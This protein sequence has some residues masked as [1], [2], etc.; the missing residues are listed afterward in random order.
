M[1]NIYTGNQMPENK[2]SFKVVSYPQLSI[3]DLRFWSIST[4]NDHWQ[5]IYCIAHY[6][7]QPFNVLF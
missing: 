1:L 3:L 4:S 5:D 6:G 2:L 7:Q